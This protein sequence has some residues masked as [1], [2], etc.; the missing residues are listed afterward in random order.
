VYNT[1]NVSSDMTQA[2]IF[3]TG[4]LRIGGLLNVAA[5]QAGSPNTALGVGNSTVYG[6]IHGNDNMP[7]P[8]ISYGINYLSL[9]P[10]NPEPTCTNRNCQDYDPTQSW[11]WTSRFPYTINLAMSSANM[12]RCFE[13]PCYQLTSHM[14]T[15][16]VWCLSQVASISNDGLDPT[17]T[18]TGGYDVWGGPLSG[19]NYVFGALNRDP[20]GSAPAS[21]TVEFSMLEDPAM[22]PTTTACVRELYTN[23]LIGTSI[24]GGFSVTV[25]PHDLA[26]LKVFP[27]QSSC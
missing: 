18:T 9:F 5:L 22:G 21:I 4:P 2:W 23:T 16:A 7:L 12:Y 27:G 20:V 1:A 19:G 26:V 8:D 17:T 3:P 15:A 25:A 11:Y 13:G 14:P 6:T 10:Y 24:T